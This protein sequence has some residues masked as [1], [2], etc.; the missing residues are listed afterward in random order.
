M[1][2]KGENPHSSSGICH[3]LSLSNVGGAVTD[4]AYAIEAAIHQTTPL[5]LFHCFQ[6]PVQYH[7]HH[8]CL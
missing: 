3:E 8:L 4:S 5:L 1:G 6:P 2:S 7:H